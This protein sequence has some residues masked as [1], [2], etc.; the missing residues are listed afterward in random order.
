[1]PQ[2]K[3]LHS[4]EG[5]SHPNT[6]PCSVKE[7]QRL[8]SNSVLV[9]FDP[10]AALP[11]FRHTP[12]QRITFCLPLESGSCYRSYNLVN[13][14]GSLPQV[15]VKQVSKGGGS[16]YLNQHLQPGDVLNVAPPEGHLYNPEIDHTAHHI[17]LFAA[18]SGITPL[19]SVAR[20][21]LSARPDHKV[22]LIYANSSARNIML[23]DKLEDMAGSARFEVFHILGDGATG[24]D[25]STGRLDQAKLNRLLTQ[26]RDDSLPEVA[27]QSGPSGFMNLIGEVLGQQN[28]ELPLFSYSFLEQ[29]FRHQDDQLT[30]EALSNLT[31][32]IGGITREIQDVPRGQ[33]LLEAAD[34][35]GIAMPAN[36]RSGICHRCKARLI[37]G[38]TVGMPGST[39][40]GRPLPKEWILCCQQ[41]PGSD[42]VEIS[43]D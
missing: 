34:N 11:R 10:G 22:T 40:V 3:Q 37:S 35:A 38:H 23:R 6:V 42:L 33:T 27:F 24:E 29:P 5:R 17:L 15:A 7:I 28:R 8:T 18:G 14:P 16:Q 12:G 1:M 39:S 25:L 43:L 20:H 30:S 4:T 41:R 19:I 31:V 32:S 36:C 26:F 21:A 13:H 9:T 2:R